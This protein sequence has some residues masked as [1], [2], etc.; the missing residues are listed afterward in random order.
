VSIFL[1]FC[2]LFLAPSL[3]LYL[4][5]SVLCVKPWFFDFFVVI[6]LY[7]KIF[8]LKNLIFKIFF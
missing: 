7:L 6:L 1:V 8:I 5:K 4:V 2:F 3:T